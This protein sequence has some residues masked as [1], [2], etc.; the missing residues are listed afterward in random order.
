MVTSTIWM[1][2][3]SEGYMSKVEVDIELMSLYNKWPTQ[4]GETKDDA[5]YALCKFLSAL[6]GN[7]SF[8][9]VM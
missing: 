4:W 1:T 7:N 9:D 6:I 8:K 5:L 3:L 2:M